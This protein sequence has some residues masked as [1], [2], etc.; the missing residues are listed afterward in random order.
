[1]RMS[2]DSVGS[3]RYTLFSIKEKMSLTDLWEWQ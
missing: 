2:V 1:M 3:L